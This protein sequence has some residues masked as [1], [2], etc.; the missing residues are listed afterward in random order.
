MSRKSKYGYRSTNNAT[1]LIGDRCYYDIESIIKNRLQCAPQFVQ[2][3]E[4]DKVL[5]GHSGCVNCLE[6]TTN[7][8]ILAS[9]SDDCRVML[10]DPFKRK[11]ILDFHTPHRGN[12]FSVKFLPNTDNSVIATGAADGEIFLFDITQDI[13][14]APIWKCKC[15][16]SRVKRL[17]TTAD[18]PFLFWSAA[19]DGIVL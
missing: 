7:G 19:E 9:A 14:M 18:S 8:R 11:N 15:H 17:A 12:I 1:D 3:L 5:E 4:L 10:W 2:R 13:E 6:W 16:Y